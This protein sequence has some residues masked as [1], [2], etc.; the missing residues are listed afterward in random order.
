MTAKTY[1]L[2]EILEARENLTKLEAADIDDVTWLA[3]IATLL[4]LA[5][6]EGNAIVTREQTIFLKYRAMGWEPGDVSELASIAAEPKK[7]Q[8]NLPVEKWK[9]R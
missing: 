8:H 1:T 4:D 7:Q 6:T 3:R 5:V 9:T 2:D